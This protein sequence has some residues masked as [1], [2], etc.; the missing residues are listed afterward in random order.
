LRF[1]GEFEG[2]VLEDALAGDDLDRKRIEGS[3]AL[4]GDGDGIAARLDTFE[5]ERAISATEGKL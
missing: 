5:D 1:D 2:D 3:E 4:G